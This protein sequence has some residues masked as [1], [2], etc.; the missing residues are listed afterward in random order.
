MF[1]HVSAYYRIE[2]QNR[3]LG[4]FTLVETPIEPYIKDFCTEHDA[5][6]ARWEK[7]WDISN[8]AFF[9]AFDGDR[10]VGGITVA[11]RTK[12]VNLLYG[13][14][15][16][17]SLWDIRVDDEYKHQGIGQ[18]LFYMAVKWSRE[19]GLVQM[20]IECQNNNIPAVKFYH[21]QGAVLSA[22]NEYAYYNEPEYRHEAQFI[23]YFDL[24]EQIKDFPVMPTIPQF[25]VEKYPSPKTIKQ[26]VSVILEYAGEHFTD[27]FADDTAIDAQYQRICYLK[28]RDEFISGIMF[29]CLD[30]SPHITAMAT[31]REYQNKGYGKQLLEYFVEYVSQLGFHDIE[32]YAWSEKTKPI[33]ASTQAFYKRVG[34]VVEQE[35]IGLW[36]QD[37]ITVK[38]KKSW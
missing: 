21:K 13:R 18:V 30:G 37:M 36:A 26:F 31:K 22:I 32:L 17:A 10:P 23:W 9:M 28:S 35:H 6:V 1:V 34:F 29:T 20:S 24:C 27:N 19:Q 33:C 16:L 12:E 8:W 4:G 5:N 15:D 14:D 2:K 11:S 7:R 3:G 25:V 38:M